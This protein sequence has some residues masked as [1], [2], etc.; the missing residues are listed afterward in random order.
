MPTIDEAASALKSP[1][2]TLRWRCARGLVPGAMKVGRTWF[3]PATTIE[4]LRERQP[5]VKEQST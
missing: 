2:R 4:A 1:P 5:E 3:V